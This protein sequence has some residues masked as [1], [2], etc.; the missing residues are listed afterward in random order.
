MDDL[1]ITEVGITISFYVVA[2]LFS[3]VGREILSG[4]MA[5]R[6]GD[7]TPRVSNR[8]TL[9]PLK[10]IDLFGTFIIPFTVNYFRGKFH[11]WIC[12]AYADKL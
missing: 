11:I 4:L 12:K 6:Y 8:I 9:N 3:A 5:L 1:D 10:H 2:L 7:E